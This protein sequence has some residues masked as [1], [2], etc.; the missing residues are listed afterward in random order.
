MKTPIL[1][2]SKRLKGDQFYPVH[3]DKKQ[4]FLHHTAGPTADGAIN[5][6]NQTPDK[7]G[8]AYVIDRD[9]TIYQTFNDDQWAYH[10]GIKGGD[11]VIDK[12]SI[13]IE[14]VSCGGLIKEDNKFIFY[15]L[16]PNKTV[17]KEIDPSEVIELKETWR[18]YSV[19]HKYSDKQIDSV[20]QLVE[21][22]VEKFKI[23]LQTT[24]Q[25]FMGFNPLISK[26][27]LPGIWCHTSVREDKCDLYPEAKIISG[28]I[29]LLPKQP[30]IE[31]G[32]NT[33][34]S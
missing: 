12:T 28:L 25:G 29:N 3:Q 26:N 4:I 2:L 6:W 16:F 30:I 19:F 31:K 17:K 22:L 1:N 24:L 34:K 27:H 23:P 14:I 10:L 8:V 11:G 33:T 18:G 9:G 7:V 32:K 20:L 21:Y 5:W 15:P 13:G